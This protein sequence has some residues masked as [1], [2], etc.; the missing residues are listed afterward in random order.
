MENEVKMNNRLNEIR[1][2]VNINKIIKD[3]PDS[4]GIK[5]L[6]IMVN[7]IDP[8]ALQLLGGLIRESMNEK[9]LNVDR[10]DLIAALKYWYKPVQIAKKLNISYRSLRLTYGNLLDREYT[11][12]EF[13]KSLTPQYITNDRTRN[14]V[15][16]LNRFVDQFK[17]PYGSFSGFEEYEYNERTLEIRFYLIVSK[18]K[19]LIS[20]DVALHDFIKTVCNSFGL[21]WYTI[22]YLLNNMSFISRSIPDTNENR[23]QFM[24]EVCNLHYM[25]GIKK[26]EI[27]RLLFDGTGSYFYATSYRKRNSKN[28]LSDL[29]WFND[30]YSTTL[31]WTNINKEDVISF[32]NIFMK[33]VEGDI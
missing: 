29:Q 21:D 10:K 22:S 9:Y 32:I 16:F 23:G 5:I 26:G 7:I 19:E 4:I 3:V 30:V 17:L 33:I 18:L 28:L 1:L 14:T 11:T 27:S 8:E 20:N 31:S 12:S 24:Q 25:Q 2:S 6:G 13:L 15:M